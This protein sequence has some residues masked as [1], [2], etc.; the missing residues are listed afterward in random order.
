MSVPFALSPTPWLMIPKLCQVT[1]QPS[2]VFPYCPSLL[3]EATRLPANPSPITK[4]GAWTWG[5]L[6]ESPGS[7]PATSCPQ[8]GTEGENRLC[9]QGALLPSGC[10]GAARPS[11]V[12]QGWDTHPSCHR[13]LGQTFPHPC[14]IPP[15]KSGSHHA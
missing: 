12:V 11:L 13:C 6:A 7:R 15:R 5:A 3:S 8:I 4:P 9:H 10:A 1:S 2:P 14:L